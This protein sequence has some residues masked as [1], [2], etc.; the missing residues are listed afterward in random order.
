MYDYG[1]RFYDPAIGRW[2]TPDPLAEKYLSISPYVYAANNPVLFV[3]P[4]GQEI[5]IYYNDSDGNKQKLQYSQ[6]M[7]Y[8]GDNKFIAASV[9][10]LNKMNSTEDGSSVLTNLVKSENAFNFNNEFSKKDGKEIKNQLSFTASKNGG[11]DIKAGALLEDVLNPTQKLSSTAHEVFHAYQSE[12]GEKGI[13]SGAINREI[14]AFL[15][16]E[17]ISQNYQMQTTGVAPLFPFG[18]N[19]T[20]GN[21]YNMAMSGLLYAPSFNQTLYNSAGNNFLKGSVANSKGTYTG[22]TFNSNYSNP[23]ISKFFPLIKY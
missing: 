15:F 6:G 1:A 11:G 8:D 17:A 12:N 18:N 5:W 16:G 14:G 22:K 23:L 7:K 3:D 4:N 10:Y 9:G 21:N 2:S 13:S 20:A 19:T